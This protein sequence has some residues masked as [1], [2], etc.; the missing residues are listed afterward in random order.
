MGRRIHDTRLRNVMGIT[1][2]VETL[3]G[4]DLIVASPY[5]TADVLASHGTR[6]RLVRI[7]GVVPEREDRLA[8]LAA[9]TS[10]H[11]VERLAATRYGLLLGARAAD[12]L[13]AGASD[14][15]R[16]VSMTGEIYN[17]EVVGVYELGDSAADHGG[18]VN[19]RLAQS[20][21]RALPSEA[22]AVA[23][24]LRDHGDA[25]RIATRVERA[26]GRPVQSASESDRPLLSIDRAECID[27][28]IATAALI[29]AVLSIASASS[30]ARRRPGAS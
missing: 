30:A 15:V 16:V 21:E 10:R 1:R 6:E 24:R 20:I 22:S 2:S 4:D 7:R 17:L 27:L 5:L 26:T 25:N 29:V 3:L 12:A 11:V 9:S 13:S 19:L 14:R 28:S 8:E 23:I 18:I